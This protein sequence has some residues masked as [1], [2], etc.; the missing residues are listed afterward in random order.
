MQKDPRIDADWRFG[1]APAA[2]AKLIGLFDATARIDRVWIY[3]SRARGDHRESSDIDLMVDAPAFSAADLAQ[4]QG[5]LEDLGLIYR[6]DLLLWQQATDEAFR[7]RVEG[8]RK[9]FWAP[10]RPPV[11]ASGLGG[12][13]LKDL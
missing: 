6:T 8:D 10:R 3:G 1:I 4:L 12:V 9:L 5:R 11:Q 7:R 2:L 13:E